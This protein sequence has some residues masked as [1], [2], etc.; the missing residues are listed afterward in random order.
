MP[1]CSIQIL[2]ELQ[3][4]GTVRGR[5]ATGSSGSVDPHFFEYAVHMRR[6]TPTF[7]QLFRLRPPLFV[8]LRSPH[9]AFDPHL[10]SAIPI[11]TPTF[12]YPPRPLVPCAKLRWFFGQILSER[13]YT[14]SYRIV[15]SRPSNTYRKF[16][17]QPSG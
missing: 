14:I 15:S 7:C 3:F 4:F 16:G 17:E 1:A 10:L 8:T 9:A 11:S 12:R 2:R 5:G 6:L 13:N